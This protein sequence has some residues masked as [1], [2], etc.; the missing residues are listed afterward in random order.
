MA[1]P[2]SI[3]FD[4]TKI[5]RDFLYGLTNVGYY[6]S[7]ARAYT[8]G[9]VRRAPLRPLSRRGTARLRSAGVSSCKPV[10]QDLGLLQVE[11][12]ETFGEPAIDR[13]Q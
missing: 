1:N 11:R 5:M 9:K 8:F 13:S 12:V 2:R 4:H 10:E 7:K 3:W 6:N